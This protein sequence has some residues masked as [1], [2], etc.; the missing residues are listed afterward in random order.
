MPDK[1]T[2][3]ERQSC[4]KAASQILEGT[5]SEAAT[6]LE[7]ANSFFGWVQQPKPYTPPAPKVDVKA[8]MEE[9]EALNQELGSE[10]TKAALGCG[11]LHEWLKGGHTLPEIVL[12]LEGA[13]RVLQLVKQHPE[14]LESQE[15]ARL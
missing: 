2:S 15:E 3:I 1:D 14:A 11:S 4:L 5:Q 8:K 12:V 6:V 7:M 10:V 13:K 9:M